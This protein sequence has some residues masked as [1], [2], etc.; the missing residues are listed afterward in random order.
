MEEDE[1]REAEA[2]MNDLISEYEQYQEVPTEDG[3]DD[4]PWADYGHGGAYEDDYY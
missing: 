4:L 3:M 2:N 1:F